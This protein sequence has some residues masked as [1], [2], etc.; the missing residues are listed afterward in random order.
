TRPGR[1]RERVGHATRTVLLMVALG[2]AALAPWMVKN[3]ALLGAPFYPY[4]AHRMVE[5]WL[6]ALYDAAPAVQAPD[7]TLSQ[8]LRGIRAPVSLW[9]VFFSPGGLTAEGEGAFYLTNR[10]LL[11]LPLGIFFLRRK[12]LGWLVA[13]PLLYLVLIL[14]PF[15]STNLRYL[16]P[17]VPALTLAVSFV[18]VEGGRR[19][20]PRR[21]AVG[22]VLALA[23]VALGPSWRVAKEW[24]TNTEAVP[25]FLGRAS[26]SDY[27][28]T[29]LDPAVQTF[30]PMVR[31][32]NEN[33]PDTARVLL[34]F[35]ARGFPLEPRVIQDNKIT[36]WPYLVG[37]LPEGSCGEEVGA[38]YLLLAS[39]A[40]NY[41]QQR[42]LDPGKLQW[43][44]FERFA[45]SCLGPIIHIP[46]YVLF[47]WKRDVPQAAGGGGAFEPP[48][49]ASPP[50]VGASPPD[51][52]AAFDSRR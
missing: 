28:A 40:L 24:V 44:R 37:V 9:G 14:V 6:Q 3:W 25:H 31:F 47:R 10:I 27:W 50:S 39:A 17:A 18:L 49:T 22:G 21:L 32:V 7:P 5:P 36:N 23:T 45:E 15:P 4:F 16:I 33:V 20:L 42:G 48:A 46:G 1:V 19:Y 11:L 29:H 12:S 2:L 43:E 35:E 8:S 41:Y 51:P 13:P 30:A 26:S 52:R 38:D 34:L